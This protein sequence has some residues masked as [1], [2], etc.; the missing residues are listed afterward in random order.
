MGLVEKPTIVPDSP[1]FRDMGTPECF[2]NR[3]PRSDAPFRSCYAGTF[4]GDSPNHSGEPDMSLDSAAIARFRQRLLQLRGEL[5]TLEQTGAAAAATVELDQT[6]VGRLSRMDAL[7]G[8]A[9]SRELGRRRRLGLQ[10]IAA[11]LARMDSGDFGWCLRCGG[12]IDIQRL[13]L[14]P[15]APLCIGCASARED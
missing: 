15:A 7:Q 11:A 6:R 9:M 10:K 13:E 3:H 14:D 4:D 5:E 8:Q 2:D 12:E 1:V